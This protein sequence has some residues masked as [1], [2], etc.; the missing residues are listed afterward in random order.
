MSIVGSII[1]TLLTGYLICRERNSFD[2]ANGSQAANIGRT[3]RNSCLRVLYTD[4]GLTLLLTF[5]SASFS[6][7]W[8]SSRLLNA[9][10]TEGGSVLGDPISNENYGSF[11]RYDILQ[12]Y[13]ATPVTLAFGFLAIVNVALIW[14]E[15]A[16]STKRLQV[17]GHGKR[18]AFIRVFQVGMILILGAGNVVDRAYDEVFSIIGFLLV[19]ICLGIVTLYVVGYRRLTSLLR[20]NTGDSDQFKSVIDN[21]RAT[22]I[23]CSF[24]MIWFATSWFLLS[25]ADNTYG[26]Q[27]LAGVLAIDVSVILESLIILGV[28]IAL[29][30]LTLFIYK[31][32]GKG[33]TSSKAKPSPKQKKQKKNN[34][35]IETYSPATFNTSEEN[36]ESIVSSSGGP[37]GASKGRRIKAPSRQQQQVVEEEEEEEEEYVPK[38]YENVKAPVAEGPPSRARRIMSPSRRREKETAQQANA[39]TNEMFDA[40][41]DV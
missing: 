34:K 39:T 30:G 17:G 32:K 22:T 31:G 10:I 2:G 35:Q 26:V 15:I 13:I 21:V 11:G 1:V 25:L 12:E 41:D 29:F 14:L 23:L 27:G 20:G 5:I 8:S 3:S 36:L 7:A 19:P 24:G 38:P 16:E 33:R 4:R 40:E 18:R 9:L 37:P 28:L 6:I